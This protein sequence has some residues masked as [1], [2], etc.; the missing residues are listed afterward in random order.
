MLTISTM[1]NFN[2]KALWIVPEGFF[3]LNRVL[4]DYVWR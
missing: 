2:S 3:Y 4:Q 1:K